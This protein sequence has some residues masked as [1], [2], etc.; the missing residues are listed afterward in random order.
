MSQFFR[1]SLLLFFLFVLPL[2]ASSFVIGKQIKG[3]FQRESAV[4]SEMTSFVT[5]K[6]A[7]EAHSSDGAVVVRG[8]VRVLPANDGSAGLA[9][10]PLGMQV[11]G[12]AGSAPNQ[13][14]LVAAPAGTEV[15]FWRPAEPSQYYVTYTDEAGEYQINLDDGLWRG[16][17]C[18]SRSGFSPAAW[19]IEIDNNQLKVMQAI[20]QKTLHLDIIEPRNTSMAFIPLSIRG[21]GFGC[22]GYLKFVYSNTIDNLGND[23]GVKYSVPDVDVNITE[24]TERTL[25]FVMPM[26]GDSTTAHKVMAYVQYIEGNQR[27]NRLP[28]AEFR[29]AILSEDVQNAADILNVTGGGQTTRGLVDLGNIDP[30]RVGSGL[31]VPTRIFGTRDPVNT[32]SGSGVML[33]GTQVMSQEALFGRAFSSESV[34]KSFELDVELD[35]RGLTQ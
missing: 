3:E 31:V 35:V 26:L 19:D 10:A 33:N 28:I 4:M 2:Q 5:M 8:K 15:R 1:Y 32:L 20:Y 24:Q 6:T 18:G 14:G 30:A 9:V 23:H 12:Q 27:S 21:K 11:I 7:S 16:E 25:G 17:A 13:S 22:N 34:V 29:Y